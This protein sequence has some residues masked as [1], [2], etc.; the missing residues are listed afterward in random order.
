MSFFDYISSLSAFLL[1]IGLIKPH[2]VLMPNRIKST[3]LFFL[4][5][6]ISVSICKGNGYELNHK[7]IGIAFITAIA[8]TIM[9]YVRNKKKTITARTDNPHTNVANEDRENRNPQSNY[10]PLSI[11]NGKHIIWQGK[12]KPTSFRAEGINDRLSGILTCFF[13]NEKGHFYFTITDPD[14]GES[15]SVDNYSIK[16]KIL[17]GS[18]RYDVV[19]I[20]KDVFGLSD[21]IYDYAEMVRYNRK[22]TEEKERIE[23]N[24]IS[25][26][27]SFAPLKTDFTYRKDMSR[28]RRTVDIIQYLKNGYGQEYIAGFCHLRNEYRT[29]RVDRI[30]TMLS[31]EGYRKYWFAD[32][33]ENVASKNK[34]E[35]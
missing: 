33:L 13:I 3:I 35:P 20:P 32:W 8:V 5:I 18:T 25:V 7:Y 11:E 14:T 16:T 2:L 34:V 12:T 10:K 17:I 9:G 6:L 1:F 26:V 30:E 24:K 23:K 21:E 29:F 4:V 22:Q 27:F 19:D 28:T 31:S 15:Q